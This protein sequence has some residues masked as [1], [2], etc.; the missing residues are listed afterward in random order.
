MF[1]SIVWRIYVEFVVDIDIKILRVP[2]LGPSMPFL[3]SNTCVEGGL[4][5]FARVFFFV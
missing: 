1:L 4:F 3:N 2:P 5:L